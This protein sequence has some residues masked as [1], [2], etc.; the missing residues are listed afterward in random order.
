MRKRNLQT[1]QRSSTYPSP[2]SERSLTPS[3][4]GMDQERLEKDREAA[5]NSANPR[6]SPTE[7]KHEAD[8]AG[9]E[10]PVSSIPSPI[11]TS[12]PSEKPSSRSS[13]TDENEKP[14]IRSSISSDTGSS[15]TPRANLEEEAPDKKSQQS[16]DNA[17][18]NDASLESTETAEASDESKR[19]TLV[20]TKP[21]DILANGDMK[22]QELNSEAN[23]SSEA[24]RDEATSRPSLALRNPSK[25]SM[26]RR[27]RKR[28]GVLD[29]LQIMSSPDPSEVSEDESLMEGL[30]HAKFEEAKPMSVARPPAT[31][32]FSRGSSDRLKE[33][34]RLHTAPSHG[35]THSIASTP[36]RPKTGS[37]RSISSNLPQWPP[38][39]EETPPVPLAKKGA[40]SQGISK[41]I[42]ALE[43]F[44]SR[45]SGS[46]PTSPKQSTGARGLL[47]LA[48]MRKRSSFL[49]NQ[50]PP[51][52]STT[53]PPR[54]LSVNGDA[55]TTDG[56]VSE[57]S[58]PRAQPWVQRQGSMT[59][60]NA[61]SQKGESISVT[62]RI[63]R[64]GKSGTLS[65]SHDPS[66]PVQ[67]NLYRSPL[68]VERERPE[69][70]LS[71]P[72]LSRDI[73]FQ[74]IDS[75]R[76]PRERGRFSFTSHRSNS[77]TRLHTSD[78]MASRM[79]TASTQKRNGTLPK[80]TSETSSVDGERKDS[81]S[82]RLKKRMSILTMS[83]RRSLVSAFSPKAQKN[84][85]SVAT[86]EESNETQSIVES[87]MTSLSHVVDVGDV[88]VQFPDTLLWKRR[89]MRIDDQGYV[90]FSPPIM[91]QKA[92]HSSRN[93][94]RKF[95]LTDFK[96]PALPDIERQEMAWSIR[97]ELDDGSCVQCACES[98]EV[99]GRVLKGKLEILRLGVVFR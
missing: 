60:V 48:S 35:T 73:S 37:T 46:S 76:S 63:V 28:R 82:S 58:T 36:D 4:N 6:S 33:L 90:I 57:V 47:G 41:R 27:D 8:L 53:G 42:K 30:E 21:T 96:K 95:H 14:S 44:T 51:N 32:I 12:Q 25:S 72:P 2:A 16:P 79:S 74:S 55:M 50:H 56:E 91:D 81:R 75:S 83:S 52:V 39:R 3:S 23:T 78:S 98:K 61:P 13:F 31:P 88:N 85:Q 17:Q 64:T 5:R 9:K 40:L 18:A 15:V 68:T 22:S 54:D 10:T 86:I 92:L 65:V 24:Q 1:A 43:V 80:S 49:P 93:I 26:T 45:E 71:K 20:P 11:S 67:M 38:S 99:Q 77:Q 19:L 94:S 89:Y 62:A 34:S 84:N 70:S 29:P 66:E 7:R 97:M 69:T 87:D 59:E